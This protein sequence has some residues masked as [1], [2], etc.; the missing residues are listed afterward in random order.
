M[1]KIIFFILLFA[2]VSG[3]AVGSK[4]I[5]LTEKNNK[6]ILN[7][8]Q[9]RTFTVILAS[10]P[11]TGYSWGLIESPATDILV[12]LSSDFMV[13]DKKLIG[14]GGWER[15]KFRTKGRGTTTIRLI[16]HRPWEKDVAAVKDFFLTVKVK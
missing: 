13:S 10:N 15:W 9:D 7:I 6:Q 11:T 16:Y 2:N 4:E 1:K 12:L 14:S 3:C 8:A 5:F